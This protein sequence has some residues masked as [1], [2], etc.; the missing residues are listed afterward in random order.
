[1]EPIKIKVGNPNVFHAKLE[2]TKTKLDKM[3]VVVAKLDRIKAN[4]ANVHVGSALYIRSAGI[5]QQ[6]TMQPFLLT[7]SVSRV[8][9]CV[10]RAI[11]YYLFFQYFWMYHLFEM[12]AKYLYG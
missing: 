5:D 9:Y 7:S 10:S 12:P 4:E 2:P 3:L 11:R 6:N 1:M 8:G